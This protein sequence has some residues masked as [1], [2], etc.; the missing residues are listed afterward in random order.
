MR[1]VWVTIAVENVNEKTP[2]KK[3]VM[4]MVKFGIRI[5]SHIPAP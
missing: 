5:G 4:M 2:V 1:N 3:I